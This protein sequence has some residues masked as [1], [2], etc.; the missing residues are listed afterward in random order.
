[1]LY[2]YIVFS[3]DTQHSDIPRCL[4]FL[5]KPCRQSQVR[6]V[7]VIR[8]SMQQ[9]GQL[10]ALDPD[11]QILHLIR[12]PRGM[13]LSQKRVGDINNWNN[14]K[15]EANHR[16]SRILKDI[17]ESAALVSTF[18]GRVLSVRY[19]DIAEHPVLSTNLM[20]KWLGLDMTDQLKEY[21]TNTTHGSADGCAICTVRKNATWTAYR[22]KEVLDWRSISVIQQQCVQLM[23]H[24]GF[25]IYQSKQ[26][27]AA[28]PVPK[29]EDYSKHLYK[30]KDIA[31]QINVDS[32]K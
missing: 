23:R 29:H 32:I 2:E 22:W 30:L 26:Q 25:R 28:L 21:I 15:A 19:E 4:P 8:M 16:C 7:K 17:E 5:I 9:A 3:T 6:A 27:L 10:L 13:L 31:S 12:D 20:Y 1:M 11:V 24:M 14:I 18:P